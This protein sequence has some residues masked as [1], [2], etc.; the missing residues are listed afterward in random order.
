MSVKKW[1]TSENC[2]QVKDALKE[3]ESRISK[4]SMKQIK[5]VASLILKDAKLNAPVKSG[6]LRRSG[7]LEAEVGSGREMGTIFVKFGG[8]GTNVDYATYQELGTSFFPGR[9]FL[10]DAVKK[11]QAKL[12]ELNLVAIDKILKEETEKSNSNQNT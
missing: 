3:M 1:G 2:E 8:P 9:F 10:H 11:N 4:E 12:I 5:N 7:R 6:A